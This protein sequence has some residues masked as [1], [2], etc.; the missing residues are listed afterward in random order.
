[1]FAR[2][3][4]QILLRGNPQIAPITQ[5]FSERREAILLEK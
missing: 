3:L 2:R 5:I 4:P 1:M